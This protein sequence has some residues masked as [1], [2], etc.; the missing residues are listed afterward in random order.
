MLRVSPASI[1]WG[2]DAVHLATAVEIGE[3]EI[4]TADRH[5]LAAAPQFGLAGRSV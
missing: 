5:M 3:V 4:W 1:F 2:P